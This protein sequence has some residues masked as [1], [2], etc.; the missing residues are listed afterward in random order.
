[1]APKGSFQVHSLNRHIEDTKKGLSGE[2]QFNRRHGGRGLSSS[3]KE[4]PKKPFLKKDDSDDDESSS[5][6]SSSS[7]SSSDEGEFDFLKPLGAASSA[8]TPAKEEEI[9]DSDAGRRTLTQ[10]ATPAKIIKFEIKSSDNG[11]GESSSESE[12]AV[13]ATTDSDSSSESESDDDSDAAS[14]ASTKSQAKAVKPNEIPK[15]G[16]ENVVVVEEPR[17]NGKDIPSSSSSEAAEKAS[18]HV[19]SD[20]E[21]VDESIHIDDRQGANHVAPPTLIAPD[22]MLRRSNEGAHGE[23]VARICNQAR[24]DGKQFW[25]FTLPS[26]IPVSVVQNLEIPMDSSERGEHVFSHAGNDYGISFDRMTPKSSIQILIPT[27]D[28]SQYQAGKFELNYVLQTAI[29]TNRRIAQQPV[30]QVMQVRRITNLGGGDSTLTAAA[31]DPKRTPV[32]Q[33][34]GL[35]ASSQ[36]IGV[37]SPVGNIGMNGEDCVMTDAAPEPAAAPAQSE[38]VK[39]TKK[40]DKKKAAAVVEASQEASA[41]RKG[42]RKHTT[43][44]DDATA[45]A[46]QLIVESQEAEE[47]QSKKPRTGRSESPDLG[48][49]PP[50]AA[51]KKKT[52]APPPS[53]SGPSSSMV[54]MPPVTKATTPTVSAK[55]GGKSAKKTN[56]TVEKTPMPSS[57]QSLPPLP[58]TVTPVP[59]P[60]QTP[61]P[62]PPRVLS[63]SIRRE[64]PVQ[65][66]Q[67]PQVPQ[68]PTVAA[69]GRKSDKTKKRKGKEGETPKTSST[70]GEKMAT[71]KTDGTS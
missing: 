18:D 68:V 49:E 12:S 59:L 11:S 25:Y 30:E 17:V 42:K 2:D 7:S 66:P 23:D 55:S 32:P 54:T 29:P 41:P 58:K 47:S 3:T 71:G 53:L 65:A 33:P 44:E 13:K 22:F 40:K 56:K 48:S 50:S 67:V 57:S 34:K 62:L 46:E 14:K 52:M 35:K 20:R 6:E 63:S 64:S 16:K 21:M 38:Q 45:A 5:D 8:K 10:K 9:A 27:V 28:G 1:M 15:S 60:R 4:S 31:P 69:S 24:M 70:T 19:E 26:K 43:S 51:A 39:S 36:P 37:T 61:V